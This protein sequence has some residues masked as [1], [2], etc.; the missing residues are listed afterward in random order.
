MPLMDKLHELIPD[1]QIKQLEK[2]NRVKGGTIGFL[3]GASF[4]ATYVAADEFKILALPIF[5]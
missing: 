2:E 1:V 3:R 4:N 5:F